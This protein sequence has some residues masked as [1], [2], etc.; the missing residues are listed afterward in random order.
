MYIAVPH[1]QLA[2]LT[3]RALEAGKHVLVEKPMATTLA[4]AD[5]LVALAEARG[6]AL[7]V[8]YELRHAA[9]N[10]RA[11]AMLQGG[12]IGRIIGVHSQTLID[13][14]QIYW[15]VG[16][17]GRTRSAWRASLAEAGGGVVLMNTSHGL[18]TIRW[19]TGLEVVRVAGEIGTL[20]AEGVEVEDTASASLRFDN[21]AIGSLFVGA[22]MAGAA[23]DE[24][25]TL[26]GTEGQ[27]RLPHLYG[28]NPLQ[29]F[30]RRE[31]GGLAPSEWP[32]CRTSAGRSTTA[33]WTTLPR[34]C[35]M[36]GRP[37]PPAAMR[38]RCWPLSWHCTRRRPITRLFRSKINR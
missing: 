5:A 29:V 4:E 30:L 27:L 38:A 2:P 37:Q 25:I 34:P 32:C 18:D 7:G 24:R 13:K 15:Q 12:V 35:A 20:A 8:F 36:A 14:P 22:H 6:L 33:R 9:A 1:N 31:W 16:T 17:A 21:G 3:T 10:V 26:F 19:L 11:R 23:E 28:S